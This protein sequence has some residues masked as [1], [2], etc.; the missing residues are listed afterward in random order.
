MITK[1][2]VDGD[3]QG[4]L[5]RKGGKGGAKGKFSEAEVAAM[6]AVE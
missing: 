2:K 4:I 3:R 1:L 5:D 6:E